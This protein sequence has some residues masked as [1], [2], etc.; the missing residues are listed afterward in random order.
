MS[1]RRSR[2]SRKIRKPE[3]TREP[4]FTQARSGDR[5]FFSPA[6]TNPVQTKL[7]LGQ[8]GD[9]FER[10]ADAVADTVTNPSNRTNIQQQSGNSLHRQAN[11]EEAQTKLQMQEE[12]EAQTKLQMMEEEEPAQA[13]LQMQEEEEP[14]QA[15]LQMQEEEEPQAKLQMQEEEEPQAKLQMQEEEEPAQA[16]LQMQEEEE[17]AQAKLQMQEEE[18]AQ[19]KSTKPKSAKSKSGDR[20]ATPCIT[21]RLRQTKGQGNPLPDSTCAE[22]EAHFGRDFSE[23]RIHTDKNAIAMNDKLKAQAFAQGKDLYFNQGKF[24]PTSK[25]GKHLLAHELA[26]VVQQNKAKPKAKTSK[27]KRR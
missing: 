15:K 6:T 2:P 11:E 18:M 20:T 25:D 1:P 12:E 10:E 24:D 17:P 26:H 13:K 3:T 22:M 9:R 27:G 4:F 19:A 16:K 7:K 5:S 21:N 8:P 23:V 14:A